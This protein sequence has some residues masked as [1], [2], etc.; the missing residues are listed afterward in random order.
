MQKFLFLRRD[1]VSKRIAL[2]LLS[3]CASFFFQEHVLA[4]TIVISADTKYKDY[5]SAGEEFRRNGQFDNAVDAF[6]KAFCIAQESGNTQG[7]LD[8]LMNLALMYWNT[9][10]LQRSADRYAQA[11]SLARTLRAK[12]KIYI[13]QAALS[14]YDY[15][16]EAKNQRSSGNL[17]ASIS[18]FEAAIDLADYIGSKEHKLKCLRQL[19]ITYWENNSFQDFFSLNQQALA[20]AR[21]INHK[22]EEGRC[23]NNIGLFYWK[24]DNYS[25]ALKFF[26]EALEIAKSANNLENEA[27]CLNNISIVFFDLGNYDR[28]LEHLQRALSIDM[29]LKNANS[30]SMDLNNIG[31]SCRR[32]GLA[33]GNREYLLKALDYFEDALKI[34]VSIFNQKMQS[35]SLNNIGATYSL[36]NI[37]YKALEY[38]RRALEKSREINFNE[39]DAMILTNMGIVYSQLGNYDESTKYYQKAIDLAL[40]IK[41]GKILWEAYLEIANTYKQQGNFS[42]ALDNYKKSIS[43]IENIRSGIDLEELK[44]T[45]LGSDKRI[46]SFYNIIDLLI[47]LYKKEQAG[48]YRDEAFRYLERAKA[49][50]FLDSIEVS[51]VNLTEGISQKLLNQE[52]ELMNEIS[53]IHTKL[54]VPQVSS[55]FRLEAERQLEKYEEQLESLKRE[56]RAASSA[57]A[58]LRYP[59]TITLKEAQKDILDEETAVLA[60]TIAKENSYAFAITQQDLK[61]FSL[62][63]Q[64]EIQKQV[65]AYIRAITDVENQDFSI[66]YS[67]FNNLVQPGLGTA[68]ITKI[69]FIPDDILY[70]LPFET[71]ITK[72][73]STEWLI[74]KYNIAYIP[75]LSVLRELIDRKRMNGQKRAKDILALG[76][77]SFGESEAEPAEIKTNPGVSY[78]YPDSDYKFFRLRYSSLETEKIASLFKP[79][80]REILLRNQAS[81]ENFKGQRLSDYKIIHLA[82]HALIDDKKPGRSAVILSLDQDPKEDGFLQMRE[83]FN[84]KLNADL[85]TLSACQTGLGQLIKGEGIEGLSRAFFYAGASSVLLSL[86]AINDQASYQL[87]ERFYFLL[88]SSESIMNS[89][90]RAKLEMINSE[91]LSHPYYW[92]GFVVSGNADKIVFHR[93]L[94]KWILLTLSLGAGL[95][96]LIIVINRERQNILALKS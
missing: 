73:K 10:D 63:G 68:K 5:F 17:Q 59:R 85:V 50:A 51:K 62:P 67:L 25:F 20:I 82:T 89:L 87:L 70:F 84:L 7:K 30:I 2:I 35:I 22:Q 61:I 95:A 11:L 86:W 27:E 23:L 40:N 74:K 24:T 38:F 19:S 44:A 92:G 8:C 78:F 90:R 21:E 96:I 69:I 28:S 55:E 3:L 1:I 45:F 43:V 18:S 29:K 64:K 16:T 54:L 93:P 91:V 13:S 76:D 48:K 15:Y 56:I 42:A 4:S 88:R 77:P 52:T 41:G 58:N 9:G 94:N 66:G 79:K 39:A 32:K 33:E 60:Y 12:E 14:I 26:F 80:K 75:S 36:L 46:E 49:R 53:K 31:E 34:S 47:K 37:K 72:D 57:Y 65:Q 6:N 81:E 71:L 83:I